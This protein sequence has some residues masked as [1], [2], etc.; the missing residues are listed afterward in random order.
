MNR[1]KFE[2]QFAIFRE[3][4]LLDDYRF[5][6]VP[7]DQ[8]PV[9]NED[10][11]NTA[12]HF[13]FDYLCHTGWAARQLAKFKPQ[14][15]V[16]FGSYVYFAGLCSAWVPR[17]TFLDVRPIHVPLDNLFC[18]RADLTKLLFKDEMFTSISCLHTLEHIG[19]GR[20]GDTVDAQGDIKAANELMRVLAHGGHLLMV[21]P[22][23]ARP[24]V[25]FNAHRL[26]G[27]KH[28]IQL[29]YQLRL[30]EFTLIHGDQITKDADPK[31]VEVANEA[32]STGCFVF[33]K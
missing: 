16:D 10:T 29:F 12:I 2:K 24:R 3:Q 7:E 9:L 18:G 27:F 8:F 4:S 15:H 6:P 22:L 23:D 32:N 20:Y 14:E 31:L 19:L 25:V 5:A 33:T 17:F 13:T 1:E 30:Q 28:V 26:Y 21:L 11:E